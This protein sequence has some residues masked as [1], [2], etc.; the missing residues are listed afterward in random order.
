MDAV[1][2]HL[3]STSAARGAID[4]PLKTLTPVFVDVETFMSNEVSLGKMTL[5]QYLAA[6]FIETIALAIGE[7]EPEGHLLVEGEF[8]PESAALRDV[9]IEVANDPQYVFVAHNAAFDIRVLRFLLGIPQPRHVWCT[10]EGAMGAWPE[11]PGG[12]SLENIPDVLAFPKQLRKL[13]I[14]LLRCSP[15]EKLRYNIQDIRVMQELYYRQIALIPAVE[16]EV[17][18]RTHQ[19]RRHFFLVDPTRLEN[20]LVEL[21][22]QALAA[23]KQAG[24]YVGQEDIREIFN[25][26]PGNLRSVR[27]QRLLKVCNEKMGANLTSTSLKKASPVEL[28]KLPNVAGLLKQAGRMNKML[29]HKRQTAK[30]V[31]V[32]EVDVEL[33]PFRAHTFR[34]SSPSTGRGLNLHNIPKHDVAIAKPI[35]QMFRLPDHLC[36]VRA[37]L[38]NVEYRTEGKLTGCKT[39]FKTFEARL[40]GDPLNDPYVLSWRAMTGQV[41]TKK[42]PVRQ[43]AK[44]AVL[45]LGFSMGAEGYAKNLLTAMSDPK[46]GVSVDALAQLAEKLNWKNS[47]HWT[48]Q[49]IIERLGCSQTVALAAFNI[50]AAFN[51]AH[52]EFSM[53]ADWLVSAVQAVAACATKDQARYYLDRAYGYTKAPDR[54]MI[55]LI[56]DSDRSFHR[57]SVRVRCGPWVHTL[58]WREPRLRVSDPANPDEKALTV[59]K[60]SGEFKRFSRQ[61]AI[62]NVTQA[63]ARNA[64]CWGVAELEKLGF[65]DTIHIHDEALLV[66]PRTR[67]DVLAARDALIQIF[68]PGGRSP[69]G[70]ATIIRPDEITITRSLWEEES[71]I[72]IPKLNEKTGLIEGGDRWGKIER[73]ESGCLENLP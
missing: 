9:L 20:L 8:A 22:V 13:E 14:D 2:Y 39:A 17:A 55:D 41:I 3:S 4:G 30:F 32:N 59:L 1:A 68:G 69:L 62:E 42:D 21:D 35:R 36:F 46:S 70:W 45:A 16:Q 5:R 11:L 31:N 64:L 6:S 28:A 54:N 26:D 49:R 25:R 66:V 29:V 40:G 43:I 38:A 18:L 47:S 48:V 10:L 44:Q 37:D 19:Q 33:G 72:A 34:F 27:S 71:D 61:L 73:N 57:P 56:I 65:A 12:Y 23:E 51:A 15:E 63:A 53:T 7:D 60:S 24:Q 58:C 67:H 52:P 50:H